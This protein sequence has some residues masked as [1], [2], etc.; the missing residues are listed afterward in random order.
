MTRALVLVM[1]LLWVMLAAVQPLPVV[2]DSGPDPELVRVVQMN[3][4][5]YFQAQELNKAFGASV[6]DDLLDRRLR[7]TLYGEQFI[8]LTD[9]PYVNRGS[10]HF[11][12][13]WPVL[14]QEDRYYIPLCFLTSILPLALPDRV[15]YDGAAHEIHAALPVDNTIRTIVIDAGHGGKDPGALG[16]SKNSYEKDVVLEVALQL[17]DVLRRELPEVEVLLTRHDDTFIP[18]DE[19]SRL[20]N[21]R[22]GDLFISLHCNAFA[23]RSCNGVEV[24]F[25][26][27]AKTTD[28]RAVEALENSVVYKYEGG[29]EAVQRYDDLSFILMDMAQTEQLRESSELAYKLLANLVSTTGLHNRG[30]RQ[31]NLYVL[32]VSY[33]P[34]VLV[35]LGFISNRNEEKKLHDDAFL[36]KMVMALAEGI[37]S[38]KYKYDQVR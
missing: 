15:R 20:A 32:R 8:F 28:E 16:P 2:F 23:D 25:L 37:K 6:A 9:S 35:E 3:G 14:R 17:R 22:G 27:T 31:A 33:M 29:A 13:T 38:F 36:T 34:A 5:S 4:T 30:V 1:W 26:S 12:C 21:E 7:V 11:N 24:Y 10:D 18:L 19:R